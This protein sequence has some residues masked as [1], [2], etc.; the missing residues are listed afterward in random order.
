MSKGPPWLLRRLTGNLLLRT[1]LTC[2]P[3]LR[4]RPATQMY[5]CCILVRCETT[6]CILYKCLAP[7]SCQNHFRYSTT[8]RRRHLDAG[9]PLRC[10]S[11]CVHFHSASDSQNIRSCDEFRCVSSKS[12]SRIPLFRMLRMSKPRVLKTRPMRRLRWQNVG[13]SS[14]HRSARRYFSEPRSVLTIPD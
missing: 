8:S 14:L 6:I 2:A 9:A 4:S 3:V 12:D 13:S 11:D 7:T 10:K 1:G 5:P